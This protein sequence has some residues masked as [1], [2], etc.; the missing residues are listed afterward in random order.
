MQPVRAD[1][2]IGNVGC[3]IFFKK[4][5]VA[6]N[7]PDIRLLPRNRLEFDA[8]KKLIGPKMIKTCTGPA[9][10]EHLDELA[11]LRIEVFRDWPYLYEGNEK[12]EKKYLKTFAKAPGAVLVLAFEGEKIIGASTG[13]PMSRETWNVQRPFRAKGMDVGRFFYFSESVLD[14]NHRGKGLGV[15]FFEEREAWARS[16]GGFDWLAFCGVVR[17]ENHPLRPENYRPLDFFWKK[18]GFERAD[19]LVCQMDWQD[20]GEAAESRKDLQFW[21][22][23]IG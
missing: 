23:N 16:L 3:P 7:G 21:W 13:L 11:R 22:K 4:N 17:P 5:S 10:L 2:G 18:R 9:I 15:R 8:F 20:V 19:G 14:K 12:Y 1:S 6:E